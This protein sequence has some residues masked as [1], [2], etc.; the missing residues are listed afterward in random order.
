MDT[1]LKS[2]HFMFLSLDLNSVLTT[3]AF[4]MSLLKFQHHTNLDSMPCQT[5]NIQTGIIIFTSQHMYSLLNQP[6]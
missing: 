2:F 3:T 4:P 5:N 6:T 1:C